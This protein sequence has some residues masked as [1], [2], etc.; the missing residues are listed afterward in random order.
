MWSSVRPYLALPGEITGFEH[1]YL[2]KMN[3]VGLVVFC[4]H[5]P[6]FTLIAWANSTGPG[7]AAGLT[8][9]VLVGPALAMW[10]LKNPRVVSMVYGFAAMCMGALLVH[11]GQGPMQIEMHFYF[12]SVLAVLAMFANPAVILTAAVTVTLHH[13]SFWAFLPESIFNYDASFWVVLVH[14]AFVVL[15]SIAACFISR[16]FFDNV[17]GLEKIVAARTAALNERNT[18]MR[19]LLDSVQQG[20]LTLD[21]DGVVSRERSAI[22]SDW[23]PAISEGDRFWEA[24]APL[25]STAA[26]WFELGWDEVVE[27]LMPIE[28]SLSQLPSRV[29]RDGVHLRLDYTP[30]YGAGEELDRLMVVITDITA[31]IE[32]E[33]LEARQKETLTVFEKILSDKNGFLEF[34]AEAEDLV[35]SITS[36]RFESSSQ[37][38]R[39]I[40]TLKGNAAL[41]GLATFASHCHTLEDTI[42]Q[43]GEAPGEKVR[44]E[45]ASEWTSVRVNLQRLLGQRQTRQIALG[46]Q[47]YADI[48]KSV[49]D[50]ESHEEIARKIAMWRMEP[51]EVRLQ[52]IA[53]QARAIAGRMGKPDLHVDLDARDLRLD[54]SE[55]AGFWSSFVHVIRNAIDH[56]IE[57]PDERTAQ[58][59]P[60]NGHLTLRTASVGDA[61]VVEIGDDGRG[62]N[63]EAIRARAVS[64]GL[65]TE[66][67]D[68]LVQALFTDGVSSRDEISELSGRG[69]GMAAI[70]QACSDK[71]GTI[72]LDTAPGAGTTFRF[73][74]PASVLTPPMLQAA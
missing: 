73:S 48:L 62:I 47:Q 33:Q 2:A 28:L 9:L 68:D 20:F 34:F 40:H 4:L 38:R 41:F 23:L 36:G 19:R 71:G 10:K 5:L 72:S 55:W 67:R 59:K 63:W 45:L 56:G 51:T 1:D 53:T 16:S 69:V 37:A 65:P 57:T 58:G 74:F 22:V 49:L 3:R 25:D 15:E 14:A 52:R 27:Q 35:E 8:A 42:D 70:R 29:V 66:T 54:P 18:D 64:M 6:V 26:E 17:I 32:R 44:A 21:L 11:F 50:R 12:F 46:D 31:E 39:W 30:L 61:F 43:T 7:L 13:L 24:L 60:A